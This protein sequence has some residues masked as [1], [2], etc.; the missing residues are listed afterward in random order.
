MFKLI[1]HPK[2]DKAMKKFLAIFLVLTL[3]FAFAACDKNGEDDES[4]T[5]P[6][7]QTD[8]NDVTNKN[9][10][11]SRPNKEEKTTAEPFENP[12]LT[13]PA[14]LFKV[15]DVKDYDLKE[16][17]PNTTASSGVTFIAKRYTA[18]NQVVNTIP[19]TVSVGS[20]QFV[21][22]QTTLSDIVADG[23]TPEGRTDV[24]QAVE[25]GEETNALIKNAQ[26]KIIKIK[27]M[28]RTSNI[29]AA[30][31]CV[32]S[33]VGIVKTIKSDN[34]WADFK[35]GDTV[36]TSSAYAEV[37]N[38][39]GAPKNIT[40]A[41]YYKGNTFNYSKATL[42]YEQKADNLTYSVSIGYTDENGKATLESFIVSAK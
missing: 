18:K 24:N 14:K 17:K 21:F 42:V 34:E 28:N 32:V 36:N 2:G 5:N 7:E 31:D 16:G 8:N 22:M 25:P 27:L 4:T 11:S 1:F 15:V 3:L 39:L 6:T 19:D 40:V 13:E 33:E 41:E 37:V 12:N 20:S 30:G 35:L 29:A 38:G 9:E 26:G 10:N 23:W